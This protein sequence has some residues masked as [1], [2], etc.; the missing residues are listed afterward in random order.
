MQKISVPVNSTMEEKDDLCKEGYVC[1]EDFK[2]NGKLC[3]RLL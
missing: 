1:N 2:G 3:E